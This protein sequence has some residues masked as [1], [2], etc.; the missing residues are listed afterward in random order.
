MF[1]ILQNSI[2]I[3]L[4]GLVL[5]NVV[6]AEGNITKSK[7]WS[8]MEQEA[9]QSGYHLISTQDAQKWYEHHETFIAIDVRPDYEYEEEHLLKALNV[10]FDLGP[11]NKISQ[12]KKKQFLKTLGEDKSVKILI[13]CRSHS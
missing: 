7:W 2:L 5:I 1:R 3:L 12:K 11:R 8:R 9:K 10:E 4:T 6:M 13:Y